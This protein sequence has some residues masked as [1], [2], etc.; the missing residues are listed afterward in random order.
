MEFFYFL[1]LGLK[2]EGFR[3]QRYMK[4]FLL[5][6]HGHFLKT[7]RARKFHL[8][9][10]VKGSVFR[11]ISFHL[12]KC[13]FFNIWARKIHFPKY[14]NS[15]FWRGMP[16]VIPLQTT[17]GAIKGSCIEEKVEKWNHHFHYLLG[18]APALED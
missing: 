18:S 12:K 17:Q 6:K 4:C 5:R 7:I 2:S 1:R 10:K 16:Q 9:S 15:F 3:F 13:N 11:N 14:R 8:G